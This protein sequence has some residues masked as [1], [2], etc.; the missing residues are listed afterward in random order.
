V[1][2]LEALKDVSLKVGDGTVLGV[3]GANG[4]GK[5]SLLR[6]I[7]GILPPT[8][9]RVEVRGRV[10]TLLALGVAL[11]RDL[12]GRDNITLG[13]LAAGMT[14]AEIDERYDKI[15]DWAELRDVID[16]PMRAYSSGMAGR[17]GFSVA[18]HMDPDVV[19]VDEA[20][21]VG[22]ARFRRKSFAKMQELC[23]EGRTV[24]LV[25]HGLRNI[26]QLCDE[27]IWIRD[28]RI[29]A[30]DEPEPVIAAYADFFDIELGPLDSEDI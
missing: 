23:G 7:A 30:H 11:N 14:R 10:S 26:R 12:S 9:G 8:E 3:V 22:D 25:S 28:G 20:L 15:V 18:V 19:L 24:V 5:S 27:A 17:L 13:G 21:S 29:V 4:A 1:R 6:T 2:E 16:V